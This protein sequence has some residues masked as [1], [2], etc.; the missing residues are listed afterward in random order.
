MSNMAFAALL[1]RMGRTDFVPHGL[2]ST[3]RTWAAEQTNYPREV[4][5]MALAH[6]L[7]NAV[8][9]SYQR[10]DMFERRKALMVDWADFTIGKDGK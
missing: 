3:F 7:G 4:C 10:G 8:E 9:Q 2:R 1:K 5:E 6:T